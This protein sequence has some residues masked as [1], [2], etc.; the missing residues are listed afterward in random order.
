MDDRKGE[1]AEFRE[2]AQ[3]LLWIADLVTRDD[4]RKILFQAAA[5][6]RDRAS[7]L[8]EMINAEQA[9]KTARTVQSVEVMPSKWTIQPK[10]RADKR[11]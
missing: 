2:R 3:Q 1:A 10:R 11:R 8:E 9:R 6:Y 5:E 7:Q 4:A